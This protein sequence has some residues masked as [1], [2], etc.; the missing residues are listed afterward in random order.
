MNSARLSTRRLDASFFLGPSGVLLCVHRHMKRCLN[1]F[2]HFDFKTS[3]APVDPDHLEVGRWTYNIVA[4]GKLRTRY[5]PEWWATHERCEVN[6]VVA[7]TFI[8]PSQKAVLVD[9][10][11]SRVING[12]KVCFVRLEEAACAAREAGRKGLPVPPQQWLVTKNPTKKVRV[13]G[14]SCPRAPLHQR[15]HALLTPSLLSSPSPV[16]SSGTSST[17]SPSSSP[18]VCCS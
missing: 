7:E 17:T 12:T 13:H 8:R 1:K 15:A 6:P 4:R 16:S 3:V 9:Q 5:F 11:V 14:L 10:R 18:S 2:G